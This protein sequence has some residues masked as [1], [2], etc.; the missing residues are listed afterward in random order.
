MRAPAGATERFPLP[1]FLS[2]LQG[3]CL[4]P[5]Q[6]PGCASL[7]RGYSLCAAPRRALD[8]HAISTWQNELLR[9]TRMRAAGRTGAS[10]RAT[11]ELTPQ[12]KPMGFDPR[13]PS[14]LSSAGLWRARPQVLER[15]RAIFGTDSLAF[16][17]QCWPGSMRYQV[18]RNVTK[19]GVPGSRLQ[20]TS[21]AIDH[22]CE[23]VD[24][25]GKGFE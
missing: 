10:G 5:S 19:W 25:F 4:R 17:G 14:P 7:A 11:A 13:T 20:P 3:S 18:P 8:L 16:W 23:L 12:L 2:P 15:Y 24:S 1:W 9:L 21:R 22:L 6:S